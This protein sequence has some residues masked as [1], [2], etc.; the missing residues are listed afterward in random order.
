MAEAGQRARAEAVRD[1]IL[2]AGWAQRADFDF[3]SEPLAD[4]IAL[5]KA[6]ADR[7]GSGPV[8]LVDH[9]DNCNSGGVCD[10]MTVIGAAI[11]QG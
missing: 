4:S 5:A 8:V 2:A 6:L 1:R 7:P 3:H 9:A 10:S 11:E